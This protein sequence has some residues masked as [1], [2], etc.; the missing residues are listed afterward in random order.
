MSD[1]AG[2]P[3]IGEYELSVD[4]LREHD[5]VARL[6]AW[7]AK[8]LVSRWGYPVLSI[9]LTAVTVFVNQGDPRVLRAA[10]HVE[11]GPV[12]GMGLAVRPD[13]DPGL[14]G[15]AERMAVRG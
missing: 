13:R 1:D 10:G 6:A 8:S 7:R 11:P 12:P 15:V 2:A 5:I 4:D 3:F 14:P 9:A